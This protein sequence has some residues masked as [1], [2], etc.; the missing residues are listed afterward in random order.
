M[1]IAVQFR[2]R[3][4]KVKNKGYKRINSVAVFSTV[5]RIW[6]RAEN[7]FNSSI[8]EESTTDS[9]FRGAASYINKYYTNRK[10]KYISFKASFSS[11]EHIIGAYAL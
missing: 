10:I 2:L 4:I 9:T 5:S 7:F 11:F 8:T 1:A 6:A 3:N